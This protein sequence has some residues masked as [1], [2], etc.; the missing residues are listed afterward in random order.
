MTIQLSPAVS[1]REIDMTNVVPAVATSI[2]GA[3]I[4]ATWG[5]VL[6]VTTI[7]SENA[8]VQR[9]GKPS[10]G[11][12]A[13]WYTPANF[14]AYSGNCLVVRT[15]TAKARN[16]VSTMTYTVD[17]IPVTTG[18]ASYTAS[19]TSAVSV[20]IAAPPAAG[21]IKQI[22][23]AISGTLYTVAPS[24]V[25]PAPPVGG[26]QATATAVLG[27][28]AETGFVTRIIVTNGGSGYLTAPTCTFTGG[29]TTG[30]TATV[31]VTTLT[32]GGTQ[33]TATPI[34]TA[35]AVSGFNIDNPGS[36]YFA[37]TDPTSAYYNAPT[38]TL[39]HGA[40]TGAVLGTVVLA[41]GGIKI[42]NEN[43]YAESFADA[44]GVS[45]EFAA[46][47]PGALGNSI[48]VSFCD[49]QT[50]ST[51]TYKDY[52]DR[53][54]DTSTYAANNSCVGDEMHIVIIDKD[55]RWS[56]IAGTVL[57]QYANVS[58][59]GDAR[60]DDGSAAYYKTV[61]NTQSQYV[62][63]TDHPSAALNWGLNANSLTYTAVGPITRDL[64]GGVD[65]L[66]STDGQKMNAFNLFGNDE[67]LDVNL[68][69]CGKANAVVANYVIQNIAEVR[70]DC[71]AFVSPQDIT[72]GNALVGI[73][74]DLADKMVAFRNLLPSS[75]YMVVDSGYKYQY[76][77]Y[78][79]KYRWV[80]LNGDVA[81][82][83]ART[84]DTNAPW[85]S[86]AG[87]NRGGV[88]NVVKLGFSPRK[89]D[90]DML[91]KNGINP[92]VSFPGQGVVL[93]GDKTGLSKPSAFDR[94][95]V[96]RLFITLEKAIATA[97]KYQLFEFNDDVTRANFVATVTP[98]LRDVKGGR[99]ITDFAVVCDLTNNTQ[100]VID[101]NRFVASIFV[102][103]A[104]SINFIELNFVATRTGVAFS[105]VAGVV[106]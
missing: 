51:W 45:G 98:F 54:P 10:D 88:K 27:S 71:V 36:G 46:K 85:F 25:I 1:I 101:T 48:R 69:M 5:P 39:T 58:K 19:G 79:D 100:Q 78:N 92:V 68:I 9:F 65:D 13:S 72:T 63:W 24:V 18:G 7:D 82:L 30:T 21:K 73:T 55:G 34:V 61:L 42:N 22:N 14:L 11:N 96:R 47:Y 40:G 64:V 94:I 53:A 41:N 76:D 104:R 12:A 38:T 56:G 6:Q 99:G 70:K 16:A 90:R 81:G 28:G 33:A 66:V 3:A 83:C 43:V 8:L 80:P 91:Y 32:L 77:R 95:N 75:S 84:D 29:T 4:D 57:E 89:A 26:V 31:G 49:S 103:P 105:E 60:K 37:T 67:D 52:F 86:P 97:A 35:G 50:F 23:V 74:S 2:G 93:F 15:D 87:L 106:G 44:Q 59:A 20:Q 62:W 17:S 102:Q